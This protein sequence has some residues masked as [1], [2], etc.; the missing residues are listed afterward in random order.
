MGSVAADDAEEKA[1]SMAGAIWKDK[2]KNEEK[3]KE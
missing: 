1:K 3:D 2:D